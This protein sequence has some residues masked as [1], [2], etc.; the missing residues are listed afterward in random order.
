MS[1]YRHLSIREREKIPERLAQ[2]KSKRAIAKG[3]KRAMSTI[4]R[5]IARNTL[6]HHGY[7]AAMAQ[8]RYRKRRGKSHR[9][10][11]LDDGWKLWYLAECVSMGWS[12]EQAVGYQSECM[13]ASRSRWRAY[14][15]R[16]M[17]GGSSRK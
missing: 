11:V 15:A 2:G 6:E 14:T 12:P 7:S 13:G 17:P 5:E 8:K 1:Y 3:L 16:S 9:K 4:T 10:Y